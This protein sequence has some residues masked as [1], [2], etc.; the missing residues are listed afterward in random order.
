MKVAMHE[1]RNTGLAQSSGIPVMADFYRSGPATRPLNDTDALA[2]GL[3]S[4]DADSA[5]AAQTR[6]ET[7]ALDGLCQPE[8][9]LWWTRRKTLL[10]RNRNWFAQRRYEV[11]DRWILTMAA[12]LK[13]QSGIPTYADVLSL[14]ELT[15]DQVAGLNSAADPRRSINPYDM[16]R[17]HELLAIVRASPRDIHAPL[18]TIDDMSPQALR[19]RWLRYTNLTPRQRL[20]LPAFLETYSYP[21]APQDAQGF[22]LRL[23]FNPAPEPEP[24]EH[25]ERMGAWPPTNDP[26]YRFVPVD[27]GFRVTRDGGRIYGRGVALPASLPDDRRGKTKIELI[28]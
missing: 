26:D 28:P 23:T 7:A 11:P 18:A 21:I 15:P 14:L 13:A 1:P 17:V 3:R 24:R 8:G 20:L 10:L 12:R 27:L 22:E 25:L 19:R 9:Y 4:G 16:N 2:W 6:A 5:A